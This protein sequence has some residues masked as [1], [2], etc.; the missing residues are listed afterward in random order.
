MDKFS[1]VGNADV[2][3]IEALY[4]Q[5]LA[6]PESVDATW[7]QFFQGFDFAKAHFDS[8]VPDNVLKEFKVLGLIDAYRKRGHLFTKTNPVRERRKYSPTLAI[9]NFGLQASDLDLVFHAGEKIGIGA[10]KLSDIVAHLEKTY[11]ESIGVEFAYIRN[12]EEEEWLRKKI[13]SNTNRT[14]FTIDQKKQILKKLNQAV[15]FEQFLDK[16]FVKLKIS[17]I[18]ALALK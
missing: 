2:N 12:V 17:F 13:E 16:K 1:F 8:E 5:Y 11:C 6:N 4:H 9:E 15:V 7:A 3:A 18:F 14:N 10:A